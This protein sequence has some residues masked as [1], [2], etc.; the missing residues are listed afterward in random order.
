MKEPKRTEHQDSKAPE[1]RRSHA[2]K[3]RG[4]GAPTPTPAQ[5]LA[6]ADHKWKPRD[7]ETWIDVRFRILE[8]MAA[9]TARVNLEEAIDLSRNAD[10]SKE[11]HTALSAVRLAL[12][13]LEAA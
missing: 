9:A 8:L 5:P 2:R 11:Y 13:M 4:P 7:G 6:I 1:S 10:R 12:L 3:P